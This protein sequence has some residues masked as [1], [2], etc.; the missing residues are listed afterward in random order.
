[1]AQ[2]VS[3]A[4][5]EAA[6]ANCR[7]ETG[8]PKDESA[9]NE[10]RLMP[11]FESDRSEEVGDWTEEDEEVIPQDPILFPLIEE[12]QLGL[13]Q[14]APS[15]PLIPTPADAVLEIINEQEERS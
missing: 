3:L 8:T 5:A 7:E 6:F 11:D 9:M 15:N 2:P 10:R 13:T 12:W 14:A 4:V 1:M